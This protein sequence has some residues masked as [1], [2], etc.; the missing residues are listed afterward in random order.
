MNGIFILPPKEV[1]SRMMMGEDVA[2]KVILEPSA[3]SGNI[4]EWLKEAGAK[5]VIACEINAD[6]QKIIGKKCRLI[7]DDFL[8]L[9]AEDISHIGMIVMNPPFSQGIPSTSCTPTK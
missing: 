1:I 7:G 2:G 4:I 9:R 8:K 6:L 5:E 3:G